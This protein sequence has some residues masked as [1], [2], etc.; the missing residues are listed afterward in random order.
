[1][2][3][4]IIPDVYNKAAILRLVSKPDINAIRRARRALRRNIFE[5]GDCAYDPALLIGL[6]IAFADIGY[7]P[8]WIPEVQRIG[9]AIA[10]SL[11]PMEG[12][13]PLTMADIT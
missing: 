9:R 3:K 7:R 6:A 8:G 11:K 12:E 2:R 13:I 10:D 4:N 1:M 5:P